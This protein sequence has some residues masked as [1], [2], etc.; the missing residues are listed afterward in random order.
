MYLVYEALI[1]VYGSARQVEAELAHRVVWRVIRRVVKRQFPDDLKMRLPSRPMRRHHVLYGLNRYLSS[2]AM[3]TRLGVAHR[4]IAATQ[5]RQLG[6]LDPSG[7][8]RGR[9]LTSPACCMRT[10]K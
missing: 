4:E 10:E 2:P 3:L 7:P 6:L 1:T 8:G 9:T 5:A